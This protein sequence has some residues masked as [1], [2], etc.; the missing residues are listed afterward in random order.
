VVASVEDSETEGGEAG[1]AAIGAGA[2][3]TAGGDVA[4]EKRR[5]NGFL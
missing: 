5:R 2:V 3:E 1:A 4:G